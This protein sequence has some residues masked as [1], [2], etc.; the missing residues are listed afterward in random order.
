M[1]DDAYSTKFHP[2]KWDSDNALEECKSYFLN[3]YL[4]IQ[5]FLTTSGTYM[6]RY[7]QWYIW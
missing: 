5:T 2:T 3:K 7:L 1:V 6:F 4:N